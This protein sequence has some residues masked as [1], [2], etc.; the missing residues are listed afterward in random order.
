MFEA[1]TTDKMVFT[2]QEEAAALKHI[3]PFVFGQD[4]TG[5]VSQVFQK[6]HVHFATQANTQ[7]LGEVFDALAL[8]HIVDN[9]F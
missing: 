6:A 7:G 9:C 4:E 3:I 1:F 2:H 8:K 5:D